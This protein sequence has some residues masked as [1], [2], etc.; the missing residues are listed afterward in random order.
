MREVVKVPSSTTTLIPPLSSWMHLEPLPAASAHVL[1]WT[2]RVTEQKS[3]T[4]TDVG[5]VV[6]EIVMV[7]QI[8][9]FKL[10]GPVEG[11]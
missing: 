3:T 2:F 8:V 9:S 4:T 10:E 6:Q 11:T 1:L 7:Q 5:L